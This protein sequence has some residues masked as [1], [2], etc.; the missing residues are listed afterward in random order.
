MFLNYGRGQGHGSPSEEDR[1]S[2]V[3]VDST[4]EATTGQFADAHQEISKTALAAI[5]TPTIKDMPLFEDAEHPEGAIVPDPDT[6][7]PMGNKF[8]RLHSPGTEED[9]SDDPHASSHGDP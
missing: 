8:T 2:T 5:T 9:D 1:T 6:Y 7:E 3:S 4:P